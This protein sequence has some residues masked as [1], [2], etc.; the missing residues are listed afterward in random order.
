MTMA[1]HRQKSLALQIINMQDCKKYLMKIFLRL[2]LSIAAP[3]TIASNNDWQ[4]TQRAQI[5]AR[6]LAPTDAR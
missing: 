4:D 5:K 3:M 1:L 6:G 2:I